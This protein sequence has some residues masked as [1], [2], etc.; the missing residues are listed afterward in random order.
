MLKNK[1]LCYSYSLCIVNLIYKNNKKYYNCWINF[2]KFLLILS[3]SKNINKYLNRRFL[4]KK[5]IILIFK[6]LIFLD[7]L[8]INFLILIL[9]DN[10]LN[11]FKYIYV[12]IIKIYNYIN[13]IKY[14]YI[15]SNNYIS[16]YNFFFIKKFILYKFRGN[17]NFFFIKKKKILAGFKILINDFVI[18]CSLLNVFKKIKLLSY[19]GFKNVF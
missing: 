9:K 13:N 2:L 6:D 8:M 17:I 14:I 5:N 1:N 3:N 18:D 12:N 19:N 15:Y 10:L 11:Y 16:N 7:N 4:S